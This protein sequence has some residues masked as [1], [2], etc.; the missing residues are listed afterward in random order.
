MNSFQPPMPPP[1]VETDPFRVPF[2]DP[3]G[4]A[5]TVR[6]GKWRWPPPDNIENAED[7]IAFKLR[8]NHQ[9]K[10]TPQSMQHSSNNG[11][12][13][14]SRESIEWEKYD[15]MEANATGVEKSKERF[16]SEPAL[17]K[18]PS[19]NRVHKRS[20][21]IGAERPIPN[22]VGKL[23]LSTEMRQ[24][25]EQVTAGHSVRS[26]TSNRSD[27]ASEKQPVK[28]DEARKMMLEQQLGASH[29]TSVRSQIQRM[30]ASKIQ[31]PFMP[32][33]SVSQVECRGILVIY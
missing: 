25:L 27:M 22:S 14:D 29:M 31:K 5:K 6:I 9:R 20:F 17:N 30:E 21:D 2:M 32:L 7:F 10:T 1:L 13:D 8:Q 18:A 19:A 11:S 33:P 12:M 15:G 4:R 24:R 26:T 3:Y 16:K 28:L 23:K